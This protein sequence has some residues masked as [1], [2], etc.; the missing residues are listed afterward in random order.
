MSNSFEILPWDSDFFGYKVARINFCS[1]N[2]WN[3]QLIR[4]KEENVKLAYWQIDPGN[5]K[6]HHFASKNNGLLV[7][8]K[9][10]FAISIIPSMIDDSHL[11]ETYKKSE[12]EQ[13]LINLGIQCGLFS[14]YAMDENIPRNKMEEL[15]TLW[16]VNSVNKKMAD[17]IIIYNVNGNIAGLITVYIKNNIGNI[18]LI[19]VD[20]TYRGQGIG[21]KLINASKQYFLSRGILNI[22][23]VTQGEN[24]SACNLYSGSGFHIDRQ[25]EFYHFWI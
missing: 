11:L 18:G 3:N 15:Y 21:K 6:F 4:L 24:K 10:T 14:R 12:P 16:I 2:D 8:L 17:D 1:E 13:K 19:G 9:T 23:V 7:D 22:E 25:V 20:E 5:E